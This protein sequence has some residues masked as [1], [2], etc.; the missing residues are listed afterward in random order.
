MVPVWHE[1][2]QYVKMMRALGVRAGVRARVRAGGGGGQGR[3]HCPQPCITSVVTWLQFVSSSRHMW[4]AQRY[5]HIIPGGGERRWR[6]ADDRSSPWAHACACV[7]IHA[8]VC[9]DE[10]DDDAQ[11]MGSFARLSCGC[12]NC[13]NDKVITLRKRQT[14]N[15]HTGVCSH[16]QI[17]VWEN[18]HLAWIPTKLSILLLLGWNPAGFQ[19]CLRAQASLLLD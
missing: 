6:E 11:E 14:L 16:R 17:C 19:G 9:I 15:P 12:G 18:T 1:W 7:Y 2:Q 13:Y 8:C 5:K 4:R 3:G 10:D